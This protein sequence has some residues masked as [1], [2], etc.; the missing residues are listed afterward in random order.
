MFTVLLDTTDL[1]EAEELV[2]A[3][4]GRI[5]MVAGEHAAST[6]SRVERSMV[7]SMSIA[8]AE[9]DFTFSYAM[10]APEPIL[11]ARIHAGSIDARIERG[12]FERFGAGRVGAFGAIAGESLIGMCR[13]LRV[14]VYSVDRALLS[15]VAAGSPRSNDPVRLTGSVPMS[16]SAADQLVAALDHLRQTVVADPDAGQNPLVAATA[17]RYI[18][19]SMLAAFPNTA[20][21]EPTAQD[22]RDSTPLLLRRAIAFI[23]DNAD[24]DISLTDIARAVYVT[25]RALQY[26]FRKHRDCTPMEY[27]RRVRLH[28]AHLDLLTG[29]QETATVGD[30]ARRWGFGH[31]GR[32]AVY[33]RQHYGQSPHVTLRGQA[34]SLPE[35]ERP[36]SGC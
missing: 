2:S 30:V 36:K 21:M 7:G 20:V 12:D 22:R 6:R 29:N 28:Q 25:P 16:E 35:C 1:G 33:Y 13:Q 5:R 26:M 14:D 15:D 9:F 32:F 24:T 31:L 3:N 17:Q 10:V 4:F 11:L 34:L 19:A 8:S 23:E 27:V 18:A